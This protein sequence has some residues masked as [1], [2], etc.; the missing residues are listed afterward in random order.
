MCVRLFWDLSKFRRIFGL[1]FTKI[2]AMIFWHKFHNRFR[3]LSW[4]LGSFWVS[5]DHVISYHFVSF[6]LLSWKYKDGLPDFRTNAYKRWFLFSFEYPVHLVYWKQRVRQKWLDTAKKFS[7]RAVKISSIFIP[8]IHNII[9]HSNH[10]VCHK[11]RGKPGQS[12][13]ICAPKQKGSDNPTCI[14]GIGFWTWKM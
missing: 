4:I 2:S 11:E 8:S 12:T 14:F 13:G 6:R 9:H 3:I 5:H 7:A 1:S 10:G